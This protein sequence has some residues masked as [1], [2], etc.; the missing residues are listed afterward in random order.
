M[1]DG[2]A[3]DG[4]SPLIDLGDIPL[5]R[6]DEAGVDWIVTNV[7]GWG[8]SA[9]TSSATDRNGADGA[10]MTKGFRSSRQLTIEGILIAPSQAAAVLAK[11][12]LYNAV[13]LDDFRVT[14]DEHGLQRYVMARRSGEI[15][16][17]QVV[18][19]ASFSVS[20]LCGDPFKY[21]DLEHLAE[22]DMLSI[23]GGLSIPSA[24]LTAPLSVP[25]T[26]TLNEGILVNAGNSETNTKILLYGPASNP[27]IINETLDQRLFIN[28]TIGGGSVLE[29]DSLK[30]TVKFNGSDRTAYVSGDWV[31][32]G[33]GVNTV[34]YQADTYQSASHMNVYWRDRWE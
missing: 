18:N 32:L 34:R 16:D 12:R 31:T 27:I 10:W 13:S 3:L 19:R 33:K 9:S 29:I 8:A 2:V 25:A 26:V 21:S 11:D 22:I 7:T 20:L 17:A 24:G 6:T 14:F 15:D 4:T 30:K 28:L 1:L 23:T 5:N